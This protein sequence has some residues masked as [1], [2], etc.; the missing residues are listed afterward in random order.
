MGADVF[1]PRDAI[2]VLENSIH[3]S[4]ESEYEN[5]RSFDSIRWVEIRVPPMRMQDC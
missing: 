3:N 2:S 1:R 4:L 5:R